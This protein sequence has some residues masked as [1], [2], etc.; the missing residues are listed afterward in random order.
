MQ[1]M[2]HHKRNTIIKINCNI[3]DKN[4]SSHK[5]IEKICL[6]ER[7]QKQD[8]S[9]WTLSNQNSCFDINHWKFFF[10]LIDEN[11]EKN[12]DRGKEY[13]ENIAFRRR[14]NE[15]YE[16]L[17]NGDVYRRTWLRNHLLSHTSHSN[18]TS[19]INITI[20]YFPKSSLFIAKILKKNHFKVVFSP[21]NKM[22]LSKIKYPKHTI[23]VWW[24]YSISYQYDLCYIGQTTC[25]LYFHL[26]KHKLYVRQQETNKPATTNSSVR[27]MITLLILILIISFENPTVYLNL[28][29]M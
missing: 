26:Y 11:I 21:I 14:W 27:K 13:F 12:T 9:V 24:I 19:N 2:L 23:Y 15:I 3:I 18:S 4:A 16:H 28:I 22:F 1:I 8:I 25:W 17:K 29:S 10:S 7:C 20:P 5:H 6:G